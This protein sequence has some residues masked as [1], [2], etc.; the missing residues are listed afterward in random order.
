MIFI[1]IQLNWSKQCSTFNALMLWPAKTSA[2][3]PLGIAVS[4]S[5]WGLAQ[6]PKYSMCNHHL[7][8]SKEGFEEFSACPVRTL[9][10]KIKLQGGNLLTC[11][12][13]ESCHKT[14]VCVIMWF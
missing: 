6:T 11:V 13:L 4:V 9:G 12:Y 14:G 10:I 2:W 8:T 3:K 1:A 7:P 5:G